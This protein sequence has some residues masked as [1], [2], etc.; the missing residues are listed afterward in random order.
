MRLKQFDV[1]RWIQGGQTSVD[2]Y[3]FQPHVVVMNQRGYGDVTLL[4]AT[5]LCLQ[6][7]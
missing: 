4:K 7:T 6:Y 1:P 3:E 5:S 2:M